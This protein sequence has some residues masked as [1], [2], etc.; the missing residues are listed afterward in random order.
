M[1]MGVVVAT[2]VVVGVATAV[3]MVL[4]ALSDRAWY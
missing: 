4:L 1:V 2:A 3:V